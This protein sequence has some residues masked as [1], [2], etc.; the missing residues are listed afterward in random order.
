MTRVYI[1]VEV[2]LTVVPVQHKLLIRILQLLPSGDAARR[3]STPHFCD[4]NSC[5][6]KVLME[7]LPLNLL[8]IAPIDNQ[9]STLPIQISHSKGCTAVQRDF[10]MLRHSISQI[11]SAPTPHSQSQLQPQAE[12]KMFALL[13]PSRPIV[14]YPTIKTNNTY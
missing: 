3:G 14:H 2:D 7:I 9:S 12:H 6:L 4:S 1:F 10:P 11:F 8:A 13:Q 5:K